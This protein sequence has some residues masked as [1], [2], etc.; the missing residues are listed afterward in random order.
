MGLFDD[1]IEH[2]SGV[3][4][5]ETQGAGV[6]SAVL[7]VTDLTKCIRGVIEAEDLF[8][9]VWVRGEVSNLTR[10]ASGH[11]YFSMKDAGALIRCVIWNSMA[12]SHRFDLSEGMGIV[13]RGR[14]TVYEKMGQYQLTVSE[15]TPDGVG[16]LYVEL[17]KL[18]ARLTA[19]GLFDKAHKQPLPQFPRKIAIVTSPTA[20]AL[21]DMV[22]IARRRMPCVDLLLVPTLMQGADSSQS[23]VDSLRLADTYSGADVIILGR[24]GGS[25]E[26]LWSFNAESV[27]RTIFAC[28]TPVVSAIG[29]ETDFTLAD[30]VAD[31]RAPTPSAAMELVLPDRME[32]RS[33][34]RG[35]LDSM[36]ASLQ[37]MVGQR[38]RNMELLLSSPSLLYP[39]RVLQARWQEVDALQDRLS[40]SFRLLT[41]A[42]TAQL[43]EISARLDSLS[44]LGVLSRGY[45]IVRR[46][47]DGAIVRRTADVKIGDSVEV[48]VSDGRLLSEVREIKDGW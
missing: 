31:L 5:Q 7:T 2:G 13:V 38:R 3:T 43:A 15:A 12:R 23:V 37:N 47:E 25:L 27:V 8:R 1:I 9:D 34:L 44:P 33:R 16:A 32:I 30:F 41:S 39:E 28:R 19:E 46:P 20:A 14:V 29:H 40:S 17:E 4:S 6:Q 26:D 22:T 48:L 36:T 24:G 11:I 21:R 35:A 45:G 18:K 42:K 10:H